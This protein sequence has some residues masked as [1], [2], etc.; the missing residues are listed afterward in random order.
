ML[1]PWSPNSPDLNPIENV[2]SWVD[3]HFQAKGYKSFDEFK[4]AVFTEFKV[5]PNK[6][7]NRLVHNMP[8][9]LGMVLKAKEAR[10]KYRVC[11]PNGNF[12]RN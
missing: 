3:A 5:V 6:M 8:K 11:S 9:R 4:E 12:V 7:I 1:S 2:W 10:I